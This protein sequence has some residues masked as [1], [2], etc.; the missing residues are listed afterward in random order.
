MFCKSVFAV[1]F[2]VTIFWLEDRLHF[3]SLYV[4]FI[5]NY[6]NHIIYKV[7]MFII[8]NS[9]NTNVYSGKWRFHSFLSQSLEVNMDPFCFLCLCN[10]Y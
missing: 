8:P 6:L 5:V 9:D 3:L 7:N 2:S 4:I 1:S 10:I